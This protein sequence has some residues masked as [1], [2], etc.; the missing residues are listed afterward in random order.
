MRL[1]YMG[2]YENE[3]QLPVKEHPA[4]YVPF[5]EPEDMKRLAVI[6]NGLAIGILVVTWAAA[7]FIT[8]VFP[9]HFIGALLSLVI[10]FPHE[11]LHAICFR[12]DVMLFTNLKQG[13][14]FVVGIEDMSKAHFIF[15]SMLP[16]LVFG[17][18]PFII[19]V[20]DPSHTILGTLGVLAISMGAGD[21]INVFNTITQVPRGGLVYM[22]GMKSFWYM[23]EHN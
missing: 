23:P 9:A 16:N 17:F 22:S 2:R 12:E 8:G 6:A 14:M 4:G 15:L 18:I 19:F 5:R 21:Y 10:L 11:I 7:Y 20:I 13:M 1:H 3:S